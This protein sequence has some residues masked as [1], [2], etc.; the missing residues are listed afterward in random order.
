MIMMK[1]KLQHASNATMNQRGNA[2]NARSGSVGNTHVTAKP[3]P[4]PNLNQIKS[5]QITSHH[6]KSNQTSTKTQP[7]LKQTKPN[8]IQNQNHQPV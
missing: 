2:G 3:K 5:H 6:I 1:K 8:Q 4:K 7:T